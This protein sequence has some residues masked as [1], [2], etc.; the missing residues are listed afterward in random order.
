MN[1]KHER[2][3]VK[4][5]DCYDHA[6]QDIDIEHSLVVDIGEGGAGLLLEKQKTFFFNIEDKNRPIIAGNVHLTIFHPDK[7][8]EDGLSINAEIVW[9]DHDY[10]SD[11]RKVGLKFVEMNDSQTA[12]VDTLIEWLS[13]QGH[14]YFHCELEKR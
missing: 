9:V 1:D 14:Y 7:S 4:R 3:S 2:R 6:L 13:K 10:S 12:Y 11:H 5:I 8:L